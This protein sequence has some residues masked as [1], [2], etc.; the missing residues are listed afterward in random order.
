MLFTLDTSLPSTKNCYIT[1]YVKVKSS[2][3][4]TWAHSP[5]ASPTQP[6]HFARPKTSILPSSPSN[7]SLLASTTTAATRKWTYN[8]SDYPPWVQCTI[9][10]ELSKVEITSTS[11]PAPAKLT[12]NNPMVVTHRPCHQCLA[13]LRMEI[14]KMVRSRVTITSCISCSIN[15]VNSSTGLLESNYSDVDSF[16]T[17]IFL[18]LIVARATMI[19]LI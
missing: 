17:L 7:S 3:I 14:I 16:N 1:C 2:F 4:H 15:I 10:T 6:G 13:I 8:S 12:H 11:T 18:I 5:H 19:L 9:S